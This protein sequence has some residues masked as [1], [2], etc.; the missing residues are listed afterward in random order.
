MKSKKPNK[1]K[2][3]VFACYVLATLVMIIVLKVINHKEPNK[4]IDALQK[5]R[6]GSYNEFVDQVDKSQPFGE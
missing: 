4:S 2:I 5:E 3:K 1:Q 6:A